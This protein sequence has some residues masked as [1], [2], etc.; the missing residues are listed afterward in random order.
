MFKPFFRKI[1]LQFLRLYDFIYRLEVIIIFF[2]GF[3]ICSILLL[4]TA[5]LRLSYEFKEFRLVSAKQIQILEKEHENALLNYKIIKKIHGNMYDD[6][7][8]LYPGVPPARVK[9]VVVR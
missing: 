3:V 1:K 2:V 7:Y 8:A 5:Y 4:T 6:I 9:G